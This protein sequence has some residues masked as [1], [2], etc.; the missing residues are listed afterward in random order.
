MNLHESSKF[1]EMSDF[2]SVDDPR[3]LQKSCWE[4]G[5][6]KE[7]GLQLQAWVP[8]GMEAT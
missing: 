2:F 6:L 7:D 5:Y 1:L 4:N 8:Q 3:I